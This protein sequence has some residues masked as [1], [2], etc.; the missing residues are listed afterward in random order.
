MGI[1]IPAMVMMVKTMGMF[2]TRMRLL[3]QSMEIWHQ[4]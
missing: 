4:R 3:V 1:L 2:V